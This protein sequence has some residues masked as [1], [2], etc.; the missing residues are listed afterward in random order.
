MQ[1]REMVVGLPDQ[2]DTRIAEFGSNFS[3]GEWTE[4]FVCWAAVCR[5]HRLCVAM[6]AV[7]FVC[8][9]ALIMT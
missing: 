5:G 6:S 8:A 2:L 7:H 9:H 4:W 1:L 3:I